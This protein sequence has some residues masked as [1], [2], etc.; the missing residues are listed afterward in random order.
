VQWLAFAK[1]AEMS[2]LS[3][4]GYEEA[5]E[6]KIILGRIIQHTETALPEHW[7]KDNF[8]RENNLWQKTR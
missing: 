3:S 6:F 4:L 7:R 2:A 5:Q 8:W 1:A